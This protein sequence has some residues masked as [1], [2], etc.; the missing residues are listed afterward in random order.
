MRRDRQG[1]LGIM[2]NNFPFPCKRTGPANDWK[3]KDNGKIMPE[4]HFNG[5]TIGM[6]W[7]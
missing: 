6:N 1:Y 4:V 5:K 7:V 2:Q 3:G